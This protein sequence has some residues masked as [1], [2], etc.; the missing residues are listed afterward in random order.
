IKDLGE[1]MGVLKK[2][3]V[4]S[5]RIFEMIDLP[6]EKDVISGGGVVKEIKGKIEFR[7]VRFSYRPD[8]PVLRGISLTFNPGETLALVGPSGSGKSTLINLIPRFYPVTQGSIYLDDR[9]I[10]EYDLSFL[11]SCISIVPQET[12]IFSGTIAENILLGNPDASF[13][14]MLKAAELANAHK[15]IQKLPQGYHTFVGERGFQLSGGER[16]RIAIARAFLHNPKI[17]LLDE[18]TSALDSESEKL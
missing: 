4:S 8:E 14:Q 13:E 18:A 11:R 16:Q 2:A 3:I 9:D 6:E 17:L 12:I 7:D 10:R 1:V 5:Q 15:F